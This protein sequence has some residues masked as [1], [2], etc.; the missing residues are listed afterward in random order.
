MRIVNAKSA[1]GR[2]VG[3][4][5]GE[6]TKWGVEGTNNVHFLKFSGRYKCMPYIVYRA[7]LIYTYLIKVKCH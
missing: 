1:C 4:G 5:M 6:G 7:Y 3:D 2:R